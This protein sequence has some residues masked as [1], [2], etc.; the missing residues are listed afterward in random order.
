MTITETTGWRCQLSAIM[1]QRA[2][3]KNNSLDI[4]FDVY[5]DGLSQQ[6]NYTSQGIM[7]YPSVDLPWNHMEFYGKR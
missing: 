3:T 2:L 7:F 5:S 4:F 6:K 1:D